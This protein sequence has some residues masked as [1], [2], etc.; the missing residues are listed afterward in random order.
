[1]VEVP[2]FCW[3]QCKLLELTLELALQVMVTFSPGDAA[4]IAGDWVSTFSPLDIMTRKKQHRER[5]RD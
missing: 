2:D 1:L 4:M 3:Y 5:E